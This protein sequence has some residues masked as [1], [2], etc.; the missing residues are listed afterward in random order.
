MKHAERIFNIRIANLI[1]S[2][3][4]VESVTKQWHRVN[5]PRCV[6]RQID[7]QTFMQEF[8]S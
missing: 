5:D 8:K 2:Q 6:I 3:F 7:G 1:S 4:V